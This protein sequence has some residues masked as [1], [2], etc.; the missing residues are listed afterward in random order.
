MLLRIYNCHTVSDSVH[1]GLDQLKQVETE[2]PE[3][4]VNGHG[5]TRHQ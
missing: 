2:Q 3:N 5:T 4:D 1:C